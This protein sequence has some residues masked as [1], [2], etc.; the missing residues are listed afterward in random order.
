MDD[1][2]KALALSAQNA[3]TKIKLMLKGVYGE[4]R[5]L[6]GDEKQEYEKLLKQK[7][8]IEDAINRIIKQAEKQHENPLDA[9]TEECRVSKRKKPSRVGQNATEGIPEHGHREDAGVLRE[10][11]FLNS[12]FGHRAPVIGRE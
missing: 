5:R 11:G 6:N 8:N 12:R 1:K 9:L 2:I 7:N 3:G 10:H 4:P